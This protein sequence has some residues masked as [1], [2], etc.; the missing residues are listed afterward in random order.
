[1]KKVLTILMLLC[2]VPVLKVWGQAT[3]TIRIGDHNAMRAERLYN[4]GIALFSKG[5]N[6]QSMQKF[7]EAIAARPDFYQAFYNRGV[8]KAELDFRG[9]IKLIMT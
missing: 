8:V 9:A 5:E 7:N 6:S 2:L 1:M 3:D 4:E